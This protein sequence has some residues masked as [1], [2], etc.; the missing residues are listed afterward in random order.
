[1]TEHRIKQ[2]DVIRHIRSMDVCFEVLSSTSQE[3]SYSLYGVWLN[4]GQEQS[5]ALH[6]NP[7][8]IDIRKEDLQNWK[9]TDTMD[10]CYRN[11]RWEAI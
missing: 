8:Y 10:K 7:V 2:G 11:S 4:M 1:M 3:N 9:K 5:W 6:N